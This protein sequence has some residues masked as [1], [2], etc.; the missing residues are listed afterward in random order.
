MLADQL[1]ALGGT[2]LRQPRLRHPGHPDLAER[3][4]R[5]EKNR[6]DPGGEH[7]FFGAGW[8]LSTQWTSSGFSTTG[9]SR[10]TTTG[11]WPLRHSTQESGSV[12]LAFISWCGTKGGT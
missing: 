4:R 11:S 3:R 5:R 1:P 8:M 10:L 2:A 12:S 6:G 9:M 7:H